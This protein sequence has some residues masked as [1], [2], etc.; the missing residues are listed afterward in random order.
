MISISKTTSSRGSVI[1]DVIRLKKRKINGWEKLQP[2]FSAAEGGLD[3]FGSSG[4]CQCSCRS[5]P[6]CIATTRATKSDFEPIEGTPIHPTRKNSRPNQRRRNQQSRIGSNS[7][8]D[9]RASCTEAESG[10][11]QFEMNFRT[12]YLIIQLHLSVVKVSD[13]NS[14]CNANVST[15][16]V[17]IFR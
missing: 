17:D 9:G 8:D 5:R 3:W 14:G 12:S 7:G 4:C 16:S 6:T 10:F 1:G 13:N 15:T 11:E 2:E